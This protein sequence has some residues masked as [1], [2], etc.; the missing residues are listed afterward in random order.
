MYDVRCLLDATVKLMDG[1][2][3]TEMKLNF[4]QKQALKAAL[5]KIKDTDLEKLLKEYKVI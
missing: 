5:G 4:A 2:K 3:P 1:K